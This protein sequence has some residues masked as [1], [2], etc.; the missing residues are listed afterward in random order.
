MCELSFIPTVAAVVNLK[1]FEDSSSS[2]I[3]QDF[4]YMQQLHRYS[5]EVRVRRDVSGEIIFQVLPALD[6]PS[7]IKAE[8]YCVLE[9]EFEYIGYEL[10]AVR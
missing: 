4:E 5:F 10:E 3:Q 8:L 9:V 7:H 2:G 6:L 1:N